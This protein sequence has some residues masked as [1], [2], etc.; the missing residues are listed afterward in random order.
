MSDA[1]LPFRLDGPMARLFPGA[2]A[3][4][5]IGPGWLGRGGPAAVMLFSA[6]DAIWTHDLFAG[7]WRDEADGMDWRTDFK[8]DPAFDH[9]LESLASPPE[10]DEE[11]EE[12]Y[13]RSQ[14]TTLGSDIVDDY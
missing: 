14:L 5:A 1:R 4:L 7:F 2:C 6:G 13:A 3:S 8:C 12:M 9:M 11:P 10:E